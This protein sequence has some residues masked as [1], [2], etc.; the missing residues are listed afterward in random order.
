MNPGTGNSLPRTPR[1]LSPEEIAMQAGRQMPFVRLPVRASVFHDRQL[2]LR[3]LAASHPMREYLLFVA[4]LAA[5]QHQ[6]LQDHPP[7]A[8]P[9]ASACAAAAKAL[10]PPMPAFG[11]PRDPLWQATLRRVLTLFAAPLA[12]GPVR[13][14]VERLLASPADWIDAQADRLSRR[15]TLGLDLATAPLIAAGLQAYWTQLALQTADVHGERVFGHTEP[16]TECPCCGSLPTA[17]ITRIGAEDGGF[18]YLHCSL[19]STQWHYV[20]IKCTHCESTKGIQFQQLTPEPGIA[21]PAT[22]ARPGAAKAECCDACHHY[23]KQVAMEKDPEVEPVADDLASI[24]LDLL[25]ADAGYERSGHNLML[26]F[27]DPDPDND[28]GGG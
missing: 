14:T 8:V 5:A 15:I 9:D 10:K 20:R 1:V 3:Q 7:V 27:G 18:R 25:V 11:W 6:A 19:C 12:A 28:G 24:T 23:L 16:G 26:L 4:D 17:S 2:R 13:D 21:L 22:G